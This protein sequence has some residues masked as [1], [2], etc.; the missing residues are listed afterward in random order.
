MFLWIS[1]SFK[2]TTY[3]LKFFILNFIL[4]SIFSFF[5]ECNTLSFSYIFKFIS[6]K[7]CMSSKMSISSISL[8]VKS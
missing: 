2:T 8:E 5:K 7:I 1:L 3:Y 4:F 6:T